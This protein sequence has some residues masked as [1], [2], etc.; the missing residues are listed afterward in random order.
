MKF[1]HCNRKERL[2]YLKDNYNLSEEDILILENGINFEYAE[3]FIENAIGY[4]PVP[5]GIVEGI[6]INN[7]KYIVPIAT[8]ETSV[9]AALNKINLWLKRKKAIISTEKKTS[10]KIGQIQF[11]RV[12]DLAKLKAYFAENN[13]R[14][15]N[16]CNEG[17]ALSMFK[18]GGGVHRLELRIFEQLD[19]GGD[20]N[21]QD[22]AIIHLYLDSCDSMGANLINQLCEFLSSV[23]SS[24]TNEKANMAILS[25][26]NDEDIAE[27]KIIIPEI[28]EKQGLKLQDASI[29]AN[30]DP[31]RA[32]THNKG[33]ANAIEGLLVA[34]AN[35]WRAV[36][37]GMHAFAAKDGHYRAL[38]S[39][40]YNRQDKSL[41][42]HFAAPI[43]VGIVGGVTKLHPV[44][45]IALKLLQVTSASELAQIAAAL[46]LMQN[47]SAILALTNEG[48][49]KGHM[50]LH[51]KNF[52]MEN[53]ININHSEKN[54]LL[55]KL[56]IM[57]EN[58]NYLTKS[59]AS[60]VIKK[61][62]KQEILK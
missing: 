23:I 36:S 42:C 62:N 28:D 16:L 46:G 7:K 1:R 54:I 3:G 14:L 41:L 5:L 47:L 38:S 56:E 8:E 11:S 17:P 22:M 51:L 25:N 2:N 19:C 48:I 26:L 13:H 50:K 37:S 20:N 32:A 29:L 21:N 33:I 43:S 34:T 6:N 49:V 31:Y 24:E 27:A 4:F 52:L 53:D 15:I 40:R 57:L 55:K 35:D 44:A 59:N 9:I 61:F 18:R 12:N 58:K 10:L 45:K 39:Y 30:I 60:E